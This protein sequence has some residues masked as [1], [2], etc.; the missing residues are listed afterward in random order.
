M[1]GFYDSHP[2]F[3]EKMVILGNYLFVFEGNL[4][5]NGI[6]IYQIDFNED[7]GDAGS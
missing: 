6:H 7:F 1:G 2:S 5:M 3:I 4:Y